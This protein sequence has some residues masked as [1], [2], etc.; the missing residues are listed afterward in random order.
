MELIIVT[1]L[2]RWS[3]PE[4]ALADSR[5]SGQGALLPAELHYSKM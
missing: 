2:P 5:W 1:E 3:D 4:V